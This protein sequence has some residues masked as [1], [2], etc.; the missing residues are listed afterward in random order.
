MLMRAI[1]RDDKAGVPQLE[2]RY[3]ARPVAEPG[4]LLVR[5]HAAGL[6]RAQLARPGG[7]GHAV[8]PL[9]IPGG[10]LSGIVVDIGA[11]VSGFAEGDRVMALASGSYAQYAAFDHRLAIHVPPSIDLLTAAGLPSWYMTAHNAVVVEGKLR[12][13]ETLL[14]QGATSGVGVAAAEIARCIGC[15]RV[16]G[17]ARSAEKLAQLDAFD[18]TLIAAA[19]WHQ[20]ALSLTDGMGVDAIIDLVG[21]GALAANLQAAALG[22]RI[23]AVGR[24]GGSSDELDLNTLARKRIRLIGVSFRARTMDQRAAIARGFEKDVLPAIVEGRIVPKI[25]RVFPM[26]EVCQAQDYLRTQPKLGKVL[27]EIEQ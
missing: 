8:H 27:L 24:L 20:Q 16:I 11:G 2:E 14:V 4:D 9:G 19:D 23:V 10:E 3:V 18:D 5:I 17:V 15:A 6:N 21:G 13:G 7:S 26:R 22:G 12:T 25:D 1:I